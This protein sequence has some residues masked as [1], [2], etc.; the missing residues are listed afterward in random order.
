MGSSS[1]FQVDHRVTD[2]LLA[3]HVGFAHDNDV[4]GVA[5]EWPLADDADACCESFARGQDFLTDQTRVDVMLNFL[6]H[7]I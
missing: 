7:N 3:F 4:E 5:R 2:V 1:H 6:Y